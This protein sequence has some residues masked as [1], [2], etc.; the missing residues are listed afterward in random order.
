[1]GDGVGAGAI[2]EDTQKALLKLQ[3]QSTNVTSEV[4]DLDDLDVADLV[5][6]FHARLNN[7]D[8]KKTSQRVRPEHKFH[9]KRKEKRRIKHKGAGENKDVGGQG[10]LMGKRG[11]MMPAHL[12]ANVRSAI[13]D[14]E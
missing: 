6:D 14:E 5:A 11:G 13:G 2:T 8:T 9:K 10:F 7:N 12:Q 1:M 4:Q 3:Q